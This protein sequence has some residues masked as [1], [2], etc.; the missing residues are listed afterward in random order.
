MRTTLIALFG[1]VLTLS[2]GVA[3]PAAEIPFTPLTPG[4]VPCTDSVTA[5]EALVVLGIGP[6][7]T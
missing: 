3:Q 6:A 2:A 1:A 7:K 4:P 5:C